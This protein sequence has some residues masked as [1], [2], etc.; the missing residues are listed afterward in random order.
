MSSGREQKRAHFRD[1]RVIAIV[2]LG[3]IGGS[4]GL[5]LQQQGRGMVIIGHD[6]DPSRARQARHLGA[7]DRTEWNLIRAC[8]GADVVVLALPPDGLRNTLEAIAAD[9][10][11][12][13]LIT[14][15]ATVKGTVLRWAE[16]L[17]PPHAA[18]VGGDPIVR[19]FGQGLDAARS[20]LFRD[21]LYC[22]TPA[23]SASPAA[24]QQS[25]EFVRLLGARP[26]FVDAEEHDGIRAAVEH[27]PAMLMTLLGREVDRSPAAHEMRQM[28][29]QLLAQ[30]ESLISEEAALYRTLCL[31]NP[32]A[33]GHW[34][35][36]M[37]RGLRELERRMEA[38]DEE[39]LTA[40][41]EKAPRGEPPE[42]AATLPTPLWR[43]WLGI[44][45]Q[46]GGD[47]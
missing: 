34:S 22:L 28:K 21:Q 36:V 47:N 39:K 31:T 42:P 29:G 27:L 38:R 16:E 25:V 3:F 45:R 1:A 9:L 4:I 37:R 24:V 40:V 33:I 20:D 5:A 43:Q 10:R 18:F 23:A 44:G 15:T 12:G 26:Y 41:F 6:R 14:D 13:C 30:A 35:R 17:L 7:I 8:E 32:S 19:S 2:G 46:K 11:S